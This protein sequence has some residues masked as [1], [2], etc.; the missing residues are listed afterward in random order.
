V[1]DTRCKFLLTGS[2]SRILCHKVDFKGVFVA[3]LCTI[4]LISRKICG[5]SNLLAAYRVLPN[6]QMRLVKS[7]YVDSINLLAYYAHSI[8]W[9]KLLRAD[10]LEFTAKVI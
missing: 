2:A 4:I 7:F 1:S 5:D 8:L 3:P 9:V 6:T 10:E